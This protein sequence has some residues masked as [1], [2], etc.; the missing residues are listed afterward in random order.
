MT[1]SFLQG[2][3]AVAVASVSIAGCRATVLKPT[4]EDRLRE[5]V[6]SL[7]IEVESLAARNR[8]LE[9]SLSAIASEKPPHAID[10]EAAAAQPRLAG[11]AI[12]SASGIR[13]EPPAAGAEAAPAVLTVYLEPSDGRGRFL[14]VTGRVSIQASMPVEGAAPALLGERSFAPAEVREAW[15]SGFM[16]TH[17][18]FEV[19]V[20]IPIAAL[21]SGH[22]RPEAS[23]LLVLRDAIGGGEFS[24]L[25]TVPI[26][27]RL[28]DPQEAPR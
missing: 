12:G 6:Q 7:E 13:A 4:P 19:P 20:E 3:L 8:E 28:P 21:R 22:A 10:A 26:D 24:R 5:Q 25:A 16:G 23:V 11:I 1:A 17:Y 9:A 2:L 15:R 27:V 18:T 14:Q